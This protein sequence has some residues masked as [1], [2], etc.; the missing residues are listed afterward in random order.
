MEKRDLLAQI[1]VDGDGSLRLAVARGRAEAMLPAGVQALSAG[2]A[3]TVAPDGKLVSPPGPAE[4]GTLE[5]LWRW[6]KR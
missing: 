4:N 2:Q 1:A 6:G 3:L 5:R